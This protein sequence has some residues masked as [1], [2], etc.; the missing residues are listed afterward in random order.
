MNAVGKMLRDEGESAKVSI[1]Q[2]RKAAMD[3]LKN[4]GDENS[5]KRLEKQVRPS[6]L[7]LL[8]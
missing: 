1:R 4:F 7:Y 2:A 6:V 3:A 5:R 8:Y